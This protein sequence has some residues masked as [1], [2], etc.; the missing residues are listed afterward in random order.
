MRWRF[1]RR[2]KPEVKTTLQI[3]VGKAGIQTLYVET[4]GP[5]KA[6]ELIEKLKD[7]AKNE[8]EA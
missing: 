5:D 6:L 4:V 3:S 2:K 7:L 1:W 8:V